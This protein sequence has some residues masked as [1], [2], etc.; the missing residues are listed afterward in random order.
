MRN[1]LVEPT[2]TAQ[3]RSPRGTLPAV[4][5]SGGAFWDC[6]RRQWYVDA[7]RVS[8]EEAAR[9]LPPQS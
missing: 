6:E 9:W 2:D 5:S 7:Q 1:G 3:R 4:V 8:L